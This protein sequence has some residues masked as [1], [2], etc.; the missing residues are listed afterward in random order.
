MICGAISGRPTDGVIRRAARVT[1]TGAGDPK[2]K[3]PSIDAYECT[4]NVASRSNSF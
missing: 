3:A 2:G 4:S 1:D